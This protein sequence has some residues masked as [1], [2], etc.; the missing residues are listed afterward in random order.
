MH[1]LFCNQLFKKTNNPKFGWFHLCSDFGRFLTGP[2]T[3]INIDSKTGHFKLHLSWFVA[4]LF[5]LVLLRRKTTTWTT[6]KWIVWLQIV[7]KPDFNFFFFSINWFI[8]FIDFFSQNGDFLSNFSKKISSI[9]MDTLD[10]DY[11]SMVRFNGHFLYIA[12]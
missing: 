6:L 5:F 2:S 1:G 4:F 7:F 10:H 11:Y 8:E 3:Y 9:N 12:I